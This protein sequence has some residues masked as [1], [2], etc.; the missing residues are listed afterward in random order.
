[1]ALP[2]LV[3]FD[4]DATL[5]EPE[6]Y[7]LMSGPKK[8]GVDRHGRPVVITHSGEEVSLIGD[9]WRILHEL[10]TDARWQDVQIAY[11]SRTDEPQWA[12]ECL[13]MLA[14]DNG[15]TLHELAHHHEIY[16]GSK[17]THFRRIHERTGIPYEH[18]VFW[19]DMQWNT[20]D[21]AGLGVV[22][23]YAP[24]GLT[25]A[26]WEKGLQQRA[27]NP[28]VDGP[29]APIT[30]Q[31]AQSVF[32]GA[33]L[34]ARAQ[35][36]QRRAARTAVV[37]SADNRAAAGFAAAAL[38]AA[39]LINAP[40]AHA[41]LTEDLLAKSAANKALNDKKRL[42]SSYSNFA[43]STSVSAG[44]CSFPNN[45]FGCDVGVVAPDSIIK[46][47]I[48]LECEG[49]DAGNAGGKAEAHT[50]DGGTMKFELDDSTLLRVSGVAAVALGVSALAVPRDYHNRLYATSS[51][52]S[53]AP[54]RSSGVVASWLGA[55]QLV[56]A[57]RDD[58]AS[59]DAKK[60]MLKV[61][62]AG[63]LATAAAH[64]VNVQNNAEQR[65]VGIAC[66]VGSAL[67]GGLCLW[68]GLEDKLD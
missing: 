61:A 33:K 43:R 60:D 15:L 9:A 50:W 57:A 40:V 51:V 2:R 41:D 12:S 21:V 54:T 10:A 63:W 29:T 64:A 67:L 66:A 11:V 68:K 62:G 25:A 45:W 4:L 5:W 3:A 35:P 16:P 32:C 7:Q 31:A 23:I 48:K 46:Q 47:D 27:C 24:Q 30:M 19:D 38:A 59:R 58:L 17:R 1:M 37:A 56:I 13:R 34:Q 42:V 20:K 65:D 52:F 44:T 28:T 49:K 18:M 6:M 39:V 55:E 36:Q 14:L 26:A 8:Q 22:A 53:E